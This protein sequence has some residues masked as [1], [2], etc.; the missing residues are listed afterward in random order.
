MRS[1]INLIGEKII[2]RKKF[3]IIS[4][5]LQ[6]RGSTDKKCAAP[7]MDKVY[8]ENIRTTGLDNGK[9]NNVISVIMPTYNNEKEI[10]MAISSIIHQD[11][12]PYDVELL[13]VNDCS[14]DN[15]HRIIESWHEK[16]KRINIFH[17]C[18]R[19][20]QSYSRNLAIKHSSGDLVAIL[21]ADDIAMPLRLQKQ[22]SYLDRH[23][24]V[25]MV[26]SFSY[27]M[28]DGHLSG[29]FIAPESDTE[30]REFLKKN[31]MPFTHTSMMFRRDTMFDAGLYNVVFQMG[32]DLAL[33][34]EAMEFTKV[35]CLQEAL[36]CFSIYS[37]TNYAALKRRFRKDIIP[38]YYLLKRYP[39]VISG[40][41]FLRVCVMSVLP[42]WLIF[43]IRKITKRKSVIAVS[44]EE[45]EAFTQ[46]IRK[47][48]SN[49]IKER[50][51]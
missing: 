44:S 11:T 45:Q 38:K 22:A 14:D 6:K 47:L 49:D 13:I 27:E 39:S 29:K 35:G 42:G 43:Q 40:I 48:S 31:I 46:W 33:C 26:G 20:G 24:D 12:G 51:V 32:E 8:H 36:V 18:Q 17:N 37:L 2:A 10:G 23:H 9:M 25:G 19:K 7:V 15:T 21:D 30:L 1:T 4:G 34:R 5:Q 3:G 16:D 28:N 50:V 41:N